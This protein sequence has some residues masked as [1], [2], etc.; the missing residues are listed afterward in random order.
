MAKKKHI[1]TIKIAA[2]AIGY[3]LYQFIT[4]LFNL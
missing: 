2:C 1:H 4:K 3:L